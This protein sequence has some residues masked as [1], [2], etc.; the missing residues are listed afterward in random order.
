M[1][2][3]IG[4]QAWSDI[5]TQAWSDMAC[6]HD[7]EEPGMQQPSRTGSK[8]LAVPGVPAPPAQCSWVDCQQLT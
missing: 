7:W 3:C 8:G 4:T 6:R 1:A 5:G 2:G